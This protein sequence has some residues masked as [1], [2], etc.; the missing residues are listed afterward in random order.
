M[1]RRLPKGNVFVQQLQEAQ[2][3]Q[4]KGNLKERLSCIVPPEKE[5]G[6]KSVTY[7]LRGQTC[8]NSLM[9]APSPD[10][11]HRNTFPHVFTFSGRWWWKWINLEFGTRQGATSGCNRGIKGWNGKWR[12]TICRIFKTKWI[13]SSI[14][15]IKNSSFLAYKVSIKHT[16]CTCMS[17]FVSET[18]ASAKA[19]GCGKLKSCHPVASAKHLFLWPNLTS[20]LGFT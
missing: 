10:K 14:Y 5:N 12:T 16:H 11:V 15:I 18:F 17:L 8:P 2:K 19:D 6:N 9:S 4:W 3:V 20:L 7:L 1:C 13:I